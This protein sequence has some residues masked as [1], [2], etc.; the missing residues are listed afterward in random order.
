MGKNLLEFGPM[1]TFWM[2]NQVFQLTTMKLIYAHT[3]FGDGFLPTMFALHEFYPFHHLCPQLQS[4]H[5]LTENCHLID[6][7]RF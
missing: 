4:L 7:A 3:H 5:A 1:W 2:E 6:I